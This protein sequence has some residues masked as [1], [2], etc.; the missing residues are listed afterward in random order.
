MN[1]YYM[2]LLLIISCTSIPLHAMLRACARMIP[3]LPRLSPPISARIMHTQPH[4]ADTESEPA[5]EVEEE[6]R[7]LL[8]AIAY[9]REQLSNARRDKYV[10]RGAACIIITT[11]CGAQYIHGFEYDIFGA[12]NGALVTATLAKC[13]HLSHHTRR[14]KERI[15]Q[16]TQELFWL[17]KYGTHEK[18]IQKDRAARAPQLS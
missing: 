11:I 10:T 5:R 13:A 14:I 12:I 8:Q 7:K 1:R 3:T 2:L 4:T 17:E 16:L 9:E 15:T 6:Q 18:K